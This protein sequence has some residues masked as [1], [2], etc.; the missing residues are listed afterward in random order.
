VPVLSDIPVLGQTFFAHNLLVYLTY[1]LIPV[2][3][4]VLYKTRL[5]LHLRATG[6]APAAADAMGVNVVGLRFGATVV[7]SMLAAM[8]GAC[9]S[10]ALSPTWIENMTAGRGWIALALIVF[11]SWNPVRVVAGAYLFG[12]VDALGLRLQA[13][14]VTQVP[15]FFLSMLPYLFTA[16][17]LVVMA[18]RRWEGAPE[19]LGKPYRREQR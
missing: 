17:V 9:L 11:S 3:W 14:G 6:E 5:G 12:G 1:L 13:S 10:L 4:W 15:S 7:G 19:A 18:P 16:G 8:G 2:A